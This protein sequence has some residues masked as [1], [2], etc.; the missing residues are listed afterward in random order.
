MKRIPDEAHP[1]RP[2]K[3]DEITRL[4]VESRELQLQRASL[5]ER[6]SEV[7]N[8]LRVLHE[9]TL[10]DLMDETGLRALEIP[11]EGNHPAYSVKSVPYYSA[12]IAAKWP[13]ERRKAAFD[14]LI[15]TGHEDLIK[16]EVSVLFPRGAHQQAEKL[17]PVA[18]KLG[19][20]G[21]ISESVH[22]GT[23]KAWLKEEIEKHGRFP[24]LEKI[25]GSVGR[26]VEVKPIKG[27]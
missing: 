2:D 20:H 18:A 15:E 5:E 22:S 7:E 10:I 11:A 16:T 23:L 14:Y 25:G 21:Q 17:L 19:G 13:E 27:E 4:I 24:D 9:V 6:L 26:K 12:T 3:L 8:K 1:V